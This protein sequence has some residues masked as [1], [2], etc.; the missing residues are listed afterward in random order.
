MELFHDY[1]DPNSM[2]SMEIQF[3]FSSMLLV[4]DGTLSLSK[5][6]LSSSVC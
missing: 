4:I 2:C 3:N 1:L 5:N 6:I